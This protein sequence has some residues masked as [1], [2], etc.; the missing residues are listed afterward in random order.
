MGRDINYRL[1]LSWTAFSSLLKFFIHHIMIQ[2]PIDMLWPSKNSQQKKYSHWCQTITTPLQDDMPHAT[3]PI[4]VKSQM[5]HHLLLGCWLISCCQEWKCRSRHRDGETS[6]WAIQ[7]SEIC[8]CNHIVRRENATQD[9][10][11]IFAAHSLGTELMK[12]LIKITIARHM[13]Q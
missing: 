1:L 5:Y 13:P 4:R 6:S 2:K 9:D 8:I 12:K 10:I 7:S 3:T 11:I